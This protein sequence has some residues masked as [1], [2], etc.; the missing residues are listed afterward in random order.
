MTQEEKR[1]IGEMRAAG[2]SYIRIAAELNISVNSMG[3]DDFDEAEFLARANCLT[4]GPGDTVT[5]HFKDGREAQWQR[6][7]H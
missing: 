3:T 2:C 7:S 5:L 6:T 4:A 1:R